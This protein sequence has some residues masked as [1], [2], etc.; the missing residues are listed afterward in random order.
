MADCKAMPPEVFDVLVDA[1]ADVLV[2]ELEGNRPE[3]VNAAGL[4]VGEESAPRH[5]KNVT[6][7]IRRPST[8]CPFVDG[9]SRL[10][11][12]SR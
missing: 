7:A 6:G 1:W 2:S 4:N 8:S 10:Q 5:P 12:A 3:R 9:R 11:G